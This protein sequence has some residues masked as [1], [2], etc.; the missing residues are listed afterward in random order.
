VTQAGIQVIREEDKT[1]VD[2]F[3]EIHGMEFS[4]GV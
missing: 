2:D 4:S 3:L 1:L